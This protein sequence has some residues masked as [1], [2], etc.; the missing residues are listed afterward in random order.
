MIDLYT[1]H[2]ANGRRASVLVAESGLEHRIHKVNFLTETKTPE[3]L[4]IN[5][6]G[7]IPVLIDN[8]VRDSSGKPLTVA[9]SGA[10]AIYVAEK[11][12]RFLPK[13]PAARATVLQW[14][15]VA[16]S[17]VS[18]ANLGI[19]LLENETPH[20]SEETLQFY[21][22][23][24]LRFW[25]LIDVRLRGRSFL[26]D[27]ISIADLM[28]YPH[29]FQRRQLLDARGGFDSVHRW[30]ALM[31]ARPGVTKGMQQ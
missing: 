23:R 18:A 24:L 8:E 6:A 17:D 1:W 27:D 31:A 11:A 25:S 30:G 29:Y 5:P 10:I 13:D 4:A 26:A 9:Q 19:Y 14:F 2:T 20:K 21:K 22:E 28:L 15:M 12:G 16:A 7:Q 3:F